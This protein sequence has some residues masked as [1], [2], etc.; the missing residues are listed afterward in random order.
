MNYWSENETFDSAACGVLDS[1]DDLGYNFIEVDS[2]FQAVGVDCGLLP[3]ID[4]DV[5]GMDDNWELI[6]NLDPTNAADSGLDLDS[7][8]LTNLEEYMHNSKPNKNDSDSDGL[9]DYNE[10]HTHHTEPDNADSDGDGINDGDEVA[11]GINPSNADTDGDGIPDG[12]EIDFGLDPTTND[13]DL[14]NNNN[15]ISNLEEFN[16]SLN[17]GKSDTVPSADAKKKKDSGASTF[18]F[19]SMLVGLML[20]RYKNQLAA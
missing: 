7:D 6:Y 9:S 16:R 2:A 18:A 20:F 8:G 4:A 5:D 15:G 11:Q 13:A 14:D 12:W 19:I 3:F 17:A 10:V 1:A